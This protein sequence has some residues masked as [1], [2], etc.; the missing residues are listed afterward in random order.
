VYQLEGIHPLLKLDVL[1]RKL[2]LVLDL[3]QLLT[4]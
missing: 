3:A 4:D 1:I 2:G